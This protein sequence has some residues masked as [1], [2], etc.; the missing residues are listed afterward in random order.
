MKQSQYGFDISDDPNI[1]NR[2]TS[3]LY[4]LPLDLLRGLDP[5][6]HLSEDSR[7][8]NVLVGRTCSIQWEGSI[9]PLPCGG[10]EDSSSKLELPPSSYVSTLV[11]IFVFHDP[12]LFL[13]GSTPI[14][15]EK[16]LRRRSPPVATGGGHSKECIVHRQMV[17]NVIRIEVAIL[18]VACET[19]TL[20][21]YHGTEGIRKIKRIRLKRMDW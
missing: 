14:V 11:S 19:G 5:W 18:R 13:A 10:S 9:W 4:F 21:G 6:A 1:P 2:R 20:E 7:A 12:L 8:T 16:K 3:L 17:V 15:T